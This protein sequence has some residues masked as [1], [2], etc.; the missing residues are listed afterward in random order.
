MTSGFGGKQLAVIGGNTVMEEVRQFADKTGLKVIA[1]AKSPLS[2]VHRFSDE[3][4]YADST[5]PEIM[6]SLL[7]EKK[8][9]AVLAVSGE[10][11]LRKAVDW[12]F[13]SS[14]RYYSTKEQWDILMNKRRFKEYSRMFG[15]PVIP[16]YPVDTSLKD[17]PGDVGFPVIIKPADNGGSSGIS[18]CRQP[19]ELR[20]AVSF[21]LENSQTQEIMCEKYL[22][23]PFFQFEIWVRD[24]QA[25]FPYVKE[26]ISYPS[27]GN[28]PVQPFVDFYPSS[29]CSLVADS[30]FDGIR[31]LF[32]SLDIRNGSCMFQGIICDGIPYIMDTGFR[33]SGGLD[34]KII[35]EEKKVDLIEAHILYA[36]T[37]KFGENFSALR[38][39]F[40]SSYASLCIGLKNGTIAHIEGLDSIKALPCVFN[41]YQYYKENDYMKSSGTFSQTAFRI[42]LKDESRELLQKDIIRICQMLHVENN[43]GESMLLPFPALSSL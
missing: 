5:D 3:P 7:K 13:Q 27:L 36:L 39:P 43:N 14:Y 16:E 24:G 25:F 4:C 17:I 32:S 41:M 26:R 22:E 20:D 6:L 10:K 37:G 29:V 38:E 34:F 33:T 8:I 35:A 31:S 18:I 2:P 28:H 30:L 1:V 12:I 40:R 19:S 21:A 9:D 11:I 42:F 15:L 23:G